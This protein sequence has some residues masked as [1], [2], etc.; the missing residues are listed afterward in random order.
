M[1]I[2]NIPLSRLTASP[3]N[4]RKTDTRAGLE[5]L[6]ASIASNGILQ[7]LI[8]RAVEGGRFE[9]IAGERRRKAA[10]I[11]CKEQ[12][13]SEDDYPIPCDSLPTT[14]SPPRSA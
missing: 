9:V 5:E 6:A 4:V 13:H 12:K 1:N 11:V 2:Q 7:N 10:K 8:V 3:T 14:L